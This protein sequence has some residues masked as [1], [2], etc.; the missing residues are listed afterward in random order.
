MFEKINYYWRLFGTGVSFFL[1]GAVGVLFW[2][3]LFPLIE[4]FIG[5]GI[6]RKRISQSLDAAYFS[7]LHGV[8]ACNRHSVL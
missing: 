1:F 7:H 6:Q 2:G 4:I 5:E 8:H 3:M